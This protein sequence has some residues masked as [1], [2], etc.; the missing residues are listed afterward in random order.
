[1]A[2]GHMGHHFLAVMLSTGGDLDILKV[3]VAQSFTTA[4]SSFTKVGHHHCRPLSPLTRV[5]PKAIEDVK[6]HL[7]FSQS[8]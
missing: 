2:A 7:V 6:A 3:S 5:I 4:A 1:M 8:T